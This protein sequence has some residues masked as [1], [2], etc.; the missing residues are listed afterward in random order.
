MFK[1]LVIFL[2]LLSSCGYPDIDTVPDF[3]DV[4]I[5]DKEAIDLCKINNSDNDQITKCLDNK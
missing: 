1:L 2:F 5:T 4:N 3:K